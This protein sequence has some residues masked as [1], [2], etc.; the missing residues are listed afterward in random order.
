MPLLK[1]IRGAQL[2]KSHPLARGLVGCWLLNE[3]S[4]KIVNDLSG[5]GNTGTFVNDVSWSSGKC[6]SAVYLPLAT[7]HINLGKSLYGMGIRRHG[8]IIVSATMR[9]IGSSDQYFAYDYDGVGFTMRKNA[10]SGSFDFYV[11]PNNH[12]ITYT[13]NFVANK[14]Y[15]MV[16]VMDGALMH[17][18]M[19]GIWVQ[20]AN[21]GEDIGASGSSV[22]IGNT[23]TDSLFG[24]VDHVMIYNRAL[25]VSEIAL[26]YRELSCMVERAIRP[27]LL[28]VLIALAVAARRRSHVGFRPI[29]GA[30]RL[31]GIRRNAIY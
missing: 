26:L 5:N 4:G 16:G 6:G 9:V 1:P 7:D 27:E 19:N 11:Y 21:L 14:R 18:Y 31:R 24:D 12:R 10:G 22:R 25:S 15:V 2:N 17:L 3:G 28:I 20:Q 8:T 30:D 23:G 29:V 13:H